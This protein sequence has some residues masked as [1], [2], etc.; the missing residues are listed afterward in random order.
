MTVIIHR[1]KDGSTREWRH[2]STTVMEK[3]NEQSLARTRTTRSEVPQGFNFREGS[4]EVF[5][6]KDSGGY[7]FGGI[8]KDVIQTRG[9]V[10]LIVDSYERLARDAKPTS[11]VKSYSNVDDTTIIQDAVDSVPDLSIKSLTGVK[12]GITVEFSNVSQAL[13]IRQ[14]KDITGAEMRYDAHGRLVYGNRLGTDKSSAELSPSSQRV[15]SFS[16]N[17][18]G[19]NSKKN[20]LKAIGGGGT[21]IDVQSPNYDA[22]TDRQKWTT[23]RFK[24]ISD[25]STLEEAA[26]ERLRDLEKEWI[27]VNVGLKGITGIELGDTF[28]VTY[29][30]E[31]VYNR[32]LRVTELEQTIDSNGVSYNATL[33]NRTI[34]RERGDEDKSRVVSEVGNTTSGV[35]KRSIPNTTIPLSKIPS[36]KA[37][38][39]RF[40]VP[41]G[42]VMYIWAMGIQGL[43]S[44]SPP[45]A[46]TVA[47]VVLNATNTGDAGVILETNSSWQP[48]S[49]VEAIDGTD[50][51]YVGSLRIANASSSTV[52]ASAYF[53]Y[54]LEQQKKI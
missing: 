15:T 20:H 23:V 36:G 37:V 34:G 42:Y 21:V 41:K 14:I 52:N 4:D 9:E 54:T 53:S 31:G 40:I 49:P 45:N 8:L 22:Q 32:E 18:K 25:A 10:E 46:N 19:G 13:A 7:Y 11:S 24:Q 1:R 33:S 47:Q 27:D 12:S 35:N 28:T 30:E 17:K 51:K 38:E 16:K 26:R 44:S 48:H 3:F 43:D 2:V 50:S 39:S 5:V 29:A 6:K